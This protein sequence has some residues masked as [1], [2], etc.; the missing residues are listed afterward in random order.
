MNFTNMIIWFARLFISI[1][2]KS[3]LY[4]LWSKTY[5]FIWEYKRTPLKEFNNIEELATY[6]YKLKW[7]PDTWKELWDATSHPEHVQWLADNE[8]SHFIGD[9]EEFAIYIA[10]VVDT[11]LSCSGCC[12][13]WKFIG[14]DMLT[15][16]WYTPKTEENGRWSVGGHNVALIK[17]AN[18]SFSYMDYGVPSWPRH[19]IDEVIHDVMQ[20]CAK[21]SILL[22]HAIHDIHLNLVKFT[23]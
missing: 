9:C 7:R 16:M 11:Q 6:M 21:D 17:N 19:T 4:S 23:N 5:Q 15:V 1:Y 8:P 14:A 12:A 10:T 22:S 13:N 18:G 3:G 20:S 2:Y